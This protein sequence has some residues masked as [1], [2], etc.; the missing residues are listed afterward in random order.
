[1]DEGSSILCI[2]LDL[3]RAFETVDIKRMIEKLKTFGVGQKTRNWFQ[4][5]LGDIYQRTT[6]N[7]HT[8]SN[9]PNDIG[10]PQGSILSAI[11]F[12]IYIN[13]M[14]DLLKNV[15]VNLFA[16]DT[17]LYGVGK[18]KQ[19]MANQLNKDLAVL[20]DWLATNKLKLNIEKTCLK[21]MLI[22]NK[23]KESYELVK[24]RILDAELERVNLFKY[25]GF[26]IDNKMNMKEHISHTTHAKKLLKR[27]FSLSVWRRT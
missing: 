27:F 21:W 5:F 22:N 9:L 17:L 12:I 24:V 16:D 23:S 19:E 4:N 13:D 15:F 8:S 25:L 6:I 18:N 14:P 1:M 7:G 20:N 2:F 11:L 3:K 10:L 26:I